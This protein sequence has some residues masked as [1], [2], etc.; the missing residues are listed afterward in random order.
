MVPGGCFQNSSI[1]LKFEKYFWNYK[2]CKLD[3]FFDLEKSV[4]KDFRLIPLRI[5]LGILEASIVKTSFRVNFLDQDVSP[6]N[7]KN[8]NN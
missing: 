8:L 6:N 7:L 2:P 4:L 3:H 5:L 1:I